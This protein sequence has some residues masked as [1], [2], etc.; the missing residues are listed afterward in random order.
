MSDPNSDVLTKHYDT[1][2][3]ASEGQGKFLSQMGHSEAPGTTLQILVGAGRIC[4][5]ESFATGCRDNRILKWCL[6]DL[7]V[8][9]C[10]LSVLSIAIDTGEER[11]RG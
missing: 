2:I 4:V 10:C 1:A 6:H 8:W 9:L 3:P 5:G 7:N 11:L